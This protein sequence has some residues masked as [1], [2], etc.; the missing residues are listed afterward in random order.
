MSI[1]PVP[2]LFAQAVHAA[3]AP[4][5][6]DAAPEPSTRAEQHR[7]VV[8]AAI[9]HA[10]RGIGP[11]TGEVLRREWMAFLSALGVG[12]RF[13]SLDFVRRLDARGVRVEGDLRCLGGMVAAMARAGLIEHDG[14]APT[15]NHAERNV[16]SAHKPVYVIRRLAPPPAGWEAA[17]AF[18][19]TPQE[20]SP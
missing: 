10:H 8:D 16:N 18:P 11:V 4:P 13:Q 9:D 1:Y 15:G 12:Q 2:P 19:R 3:A 5:S 6:A 7:S 20:G 14:W 17:A